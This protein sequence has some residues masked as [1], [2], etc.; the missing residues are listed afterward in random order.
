L[1][2]DGGQLIIFYQN[3]SR[4][5]RGFLCDLKVLSNKTKYYFLPYPLNP[6]HMN[7]FSMPNICD[8]FVVV[9]VQV[10]ILDENVCG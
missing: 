8:N 3:I 7:K 10:Q 5:I 9:C 6:I 2:Q 4:I 1:F